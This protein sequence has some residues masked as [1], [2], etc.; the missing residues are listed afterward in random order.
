MK[1]YGVFHKVTTPYHPR[2]SGQV[3]LSD[4]ELNNILEKTV[5]RS[6]KDWSIKLDDALSAYLTSYKT[7]LGTTPYQ[8]VF[9]KSYHFPIALQ[10]EVYWGIKMLNFD[11]K[12]AGEVFSTM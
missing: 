10:H 4:Q 5:D 1:K 12:A 7:P 3:E 9:A 6:G 8:L 2:T 11:L